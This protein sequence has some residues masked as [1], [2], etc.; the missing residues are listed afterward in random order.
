[1][2]N[3]QMSYALQM[4]RAARAARRKYNQLCEEHDLS[5]HDSF[6]VRD[7]LIHVERTHK[8]ETMGVEHIPQGHSQRSPAIDYLNTGDPY[9]LTVL[10][11][12]GRFRAGC[13][14]D[15]VER[16]RYD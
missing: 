13:W 8:L 10:Y 11:V 2:G 9:T 12:N 16:G 6:N 15:I 1:M 5:R 3:E 4:R 14:G 7:A